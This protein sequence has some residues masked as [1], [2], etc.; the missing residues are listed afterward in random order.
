[1]NINPFKLNKNLDLIELREMLEHS[2]KKEKK[3]PIFDEESDAVQYRIF[4]DRRLLAPTFN[5]RKAGL[6]GKAQRTSSGDTDNRT[7]HVKYSGPK[8]HFRNPGALLKE[9]RKHRKMDRETRLDI[10]N[11]IRETHHANVSMVI[12]RRMVDLLNSSVSKFD[13]DI[14]QLEEETEITAKEFDDYLHESDGKTIVAIKNAETARVERLNLEKVIRQLELNNNLLECHNLRKENRVKLIE[15]CL[16]ALYT[17]SFEDKKRFH[18]EYAKLKEQELEEEKP[19]PGETEKA[20]PP[21]KSM[22]EESQNSTIANDGSVV[23]LSLLPE[24]N[25]ASIISQV[26]TYY[27]NAQK[28]VEVCSAAKQDIRDIKHHV[29][30]KLADIQRLVEARES[31][32]E[33]L[34]NHSGLLRTQMEDLQQTVATS[35]ERS[36]NR[37]FFRAPLETLRNC[38]VDLYTKYVKKITEGDP[39]DAETLLAAIIEKVDRY[40]SDLQHFP[41]STRNKWF[42]KVNQD[43]IAE[44]RFCSNVRAKDEKSKK[45]A[46][47]ASKHNLFGHLYRDAVMPRKAPRSRSQPPLAKKGKI[48]QQTLSLLE[49]TAKRILTDPTEKQKWLVTTGQSLDELLDDSG[50]ADNL[51]QDEM[52]T[53]SQSA[54]ESLND[55]SAPITEMDPTITSQTKLN[56]DAEPEQPVA[57]Q[58]SESENVEL[59]EQ[60]VDEE[61]KF[62]SMLVSRFS[63]SAS[64]SENV[65]AGIQPHQSSLVDDFFGSFDTSTDADQRTFGQ[66]RR[67][68][69]SAEARRRSSKL[70]QMGGVSDMPLAK[71][72]SLLSITPE[73]KSDITVDADKGNQ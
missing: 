17:V 27:D 66:F 21:H 63:V 30:E 14:M 9:T 15:R 16:D 52:E 11:R 55:T 53:Q 70:Y 67:S 54:D 18:V 1:M 35:D 56:P 43:R 5:P 6:C 61:E 44:E 60:L 20:L 39:S 12:K 50:P 3:T 33:L 38:I 34:R 48:V 73:P 71:V 29:S 42:V 13:S 37:V 57:T 4:N 36:G 58:D 47:A 41:E 26:V 23:A 72:D 40:N 59:Q 69:A 10:T 25:T 62:I 7:M 49:E 8:F 45:E 19:R 46:T 22:S 65:T 31:K 24:S 28:S 68:R 2:R 32:C 51:F 64:G